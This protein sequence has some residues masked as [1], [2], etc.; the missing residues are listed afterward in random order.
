MSL[1][2]VF[3]WK[4]RVFPFS[5]RAFDAGFAAWSRAAMAGGAG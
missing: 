4:K 2:G 5:I 3:C 1:R